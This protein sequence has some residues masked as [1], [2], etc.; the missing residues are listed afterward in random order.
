MHAILQVQQAAG[1]LVVNTSIVFFG[2]GPSNV[3]NYGGNQTYFATLQVPP[4]NPLP[5]GSIQFVN[6][7]NNFVLA[8]APLS[9]GTASGNNLARAPPLHAA[10]VLL[11]P[12][13][14][15][16]YPHQRHRVDCAAS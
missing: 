8:T 4:T 3:I 11:H 1:Q 9:I 12:I 10:P 2:F 5:L 16:N 14:A 7:T 6:F 13:A 15:S